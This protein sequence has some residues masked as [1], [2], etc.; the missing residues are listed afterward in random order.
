MEEATFESSCSAILGVLP[1]MT[2]S[3]SKIYSHGNIIQRRF[4][5]LGF[6]WQMKNIRLEVL[7]IK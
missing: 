3:L 4:D 7:L 6:W 2:G 5:I 1:L